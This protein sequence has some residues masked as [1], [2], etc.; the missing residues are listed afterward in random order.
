MRLIPIRLFCFV[1]GLVCCLGSSEGQE[2]ETPS[3]TRIHASRIQENVARIYREM[4]GLEP[5]ESRSSITDGEPGEAHLVPVTLPSIL[6]ARLKEAKT[7]VQ[8]PSEFSDV[9]EGG[10]GRFLIFYL[11]KL[12]QLAVFDVSAARII[13]YLPLD[14]EDVAIAASAYSFFTNKS[15]VFNATVDNKISISNSS[16]IVIP[17][18]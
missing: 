3:K 12:N 1:T 6:P 16:C 7:T 11:K 18:V 15:M 2:K 13:K 5:S 10:G 9:T 17:V 14:A 8:L 4:S